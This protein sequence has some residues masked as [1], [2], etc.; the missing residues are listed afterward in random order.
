MAGQTRSGVIKVIILLLTPILRAIT[1][2]L[3]REL[4]AFLMRF[5]KKALTTENPIDDL[6]AGL[7]LNIFDIDEPEGE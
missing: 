3:E 7:L 4:E 5:Y 1:P 6:F 2:T